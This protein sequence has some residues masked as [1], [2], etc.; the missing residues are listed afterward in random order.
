MANLPVELAPQVP[1]GPDDRCM[2]PVCEVTC[3]RIFCVGVIWRV[4]A[5]P[6]IR[7]EEE[8]K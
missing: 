4:G 6:T 5:L 7:E 2:T 8:A 3:L 1:Q